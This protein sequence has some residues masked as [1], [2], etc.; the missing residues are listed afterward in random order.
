MA[1]CE[2]AIEF[3][4]EA[5]REAAGRP[6]AGGRFILLLRYRYTNA[7]ARRA[8]KVFRGRVEASLAPPR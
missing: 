4:I 8:A 6:S 1:S 7:P 2:N 3:S 5:T